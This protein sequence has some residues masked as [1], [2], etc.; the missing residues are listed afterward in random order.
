MN[1]STTKEECGCEAQVPSTEASEERTYQPSWIRSGA[2]CIRSASLGRSLPHQ[3]GRVSKLCKHR[4]GVPGGF[5]F[6][7][8]GCTRATTGR[9]ILL[10][11]LCCWQVRC[12]RGLQGPCEVGLL[13]CPFCHCL[14]AW[15]FF[16]QPCLTPCSLL[17][18]LARTP[19][20]SPLGKF[21]K[22]STRRLQKPS[23]VFCCKWNDLCCAVPWVRNLTR[24]Q[25]ECF[26]TQSTE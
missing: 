18:S 21:E 20:A 9:L 2:D 10:E 5:G 22:S 12:R 17:L 1:S 23:G 16:F 19:F 25:T 13:S 7:G 24:L 26:Q 6:D 8:S 3:V 4:I 11:L 14:L 15:W